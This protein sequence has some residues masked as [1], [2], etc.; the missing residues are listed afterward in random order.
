MVQDLV[1]SDPTYRYYYYTPI[2]TQC[3]LIDG[4]LLVI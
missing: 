3:M 4:I 1:L 2:I